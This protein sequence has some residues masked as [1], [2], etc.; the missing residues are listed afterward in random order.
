MFFDCQTA[1]INGPKAF[2]S[3]ILEVIRSNGDYHDVYSIEF[4]YRPNM[5]VEKT[6]IY[7]VIYT[8]A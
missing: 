7:D 5:H 1:L 4:D 8:F 3:A 6:D 2:L